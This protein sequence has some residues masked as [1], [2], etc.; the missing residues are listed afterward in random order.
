MS[1]FVITV[2]R[3][4]GD[5]FEPSSLRG[6]FSSFNRHLKACKYPKNIMEDL[7]FEQTRK[8]LEARSRQ[9]K[10]EAKGNKKNAAEAKT[11]K[12]VN[13]LYMRNLLGITIA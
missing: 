12:E 3:K 13:I 10:K 2:K 7:E 5:V 11:D 9:P 4:D 6:F 1:E 8:S